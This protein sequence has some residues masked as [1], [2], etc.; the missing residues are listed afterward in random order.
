MGV[1][2]CTGPPLPGGS[3]VGAGAGDRHLRISEDRNRPSREGPEGQRSHFGLTLVCLFGVAAVVLLMWAVS[4]RGSSG[5]MYRVGDYYGLH[6]S[7]ESATLVHYSRDFEA[8]C[9]VV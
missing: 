3:T 2:V 1:G 7:K 4:V 8:S 5:K 6:P 9:G